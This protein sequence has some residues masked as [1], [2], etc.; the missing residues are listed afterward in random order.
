MKLPKLICF[1]GPESTGKST[2]ARRMA[3]RYRTEFVPEVAREMISSN[4]FTEEDIIRIGRAQTTR[5]LEKQKTANRILFCDSDV[6]TT[7]IYSDTYL[8][9][10]PPELEE[11]EKQVHYDQYFLFDIDVPWIADGLRDLGENRQKMFARFRSELERRG[12]PY[13]LLSG[14]HEDRET[15]VIEIVDAL[16]KEL[17]SD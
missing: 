9:K 10:I 2:L 14:S 5:V 8:H 4:V 1:Y 15:K 11:L 16:L 13:V 3:E 6:I 7:A 17:G 12:I